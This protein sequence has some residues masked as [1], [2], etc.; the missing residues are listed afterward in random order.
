MTKT[1][2]PGRRTTT[3]GRR[4]PSSF[5]GDLFVEVEALG[6]AG[7]LQ[8]VAQHLLAPAALHAGAAAQRRRELARLVLGR[9][10]GLQQ[11]CDLRL[12]PA[13]LLGAG[14]LGGGHLLLELGQRLADRLE[15]LGRAT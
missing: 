4:R 5:S 12:Q 13:G 14:L 9:G 2:P 11:G 3:S 1:P 10:R 6:Q 7:R 8:H 15:G